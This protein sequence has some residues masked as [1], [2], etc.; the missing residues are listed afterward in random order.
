MSPNETEVLDVLISMDVYSCD[1]SPVET[2]VLDVLSSMDVYS[3]YSLSPEET[4]VLDILVS[5]DVHDS[6]KRMIEEPITFGGEGS[7]FKPYKKLC[8]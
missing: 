5:M 6:K 3:G 2:E 8:V 4:E 7:A 1:L